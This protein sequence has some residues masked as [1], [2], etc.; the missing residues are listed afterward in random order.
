MSQGSIRRRLSLAAGVATTAVL[1][2][3]P[4]PAPAADPPFDPTCNGRIKLGDDRADGQLNYW[5]ACGDEVKG[6]ALVALNRQVS[7][8]DTEPVVLDAATN[9]PVPGQSFSCSGPIPGDGVACTGLSSPANRTLGHISVSDDP[10]VGSRPDV[11]LIVSNGKGASAGPFR[12]S[13]SRPGHAARPLDGCP[14]QR[15]KARSRHFRR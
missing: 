3:A 7:G 9:D 15:A 14:P 12:L 2:A 1:V 13:N 6:Y 10:C 5:F 11:A 4:M 8:F